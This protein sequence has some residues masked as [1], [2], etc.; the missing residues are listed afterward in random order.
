MGY[1]FLNF[2]EFVSLGLQ[3]VLSSWQALQTELIDKKAGF[4]LTRK[5]RFMLCKAGR[6]T[7][8]THYF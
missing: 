3:F 8:P 2:D 6:N 4:P 1:I 5:A 7:R